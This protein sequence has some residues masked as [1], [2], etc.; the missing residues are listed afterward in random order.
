VF[1]RIVTRTTGPNAPVVEQSYTT[2]GQLDRI[3]IINRVT[4]TATTDVEGIYFAFPFGLSPGSCRLD[5]PFTH[6]RPGIDQLRYSAADFY[7]ICHWVEF[8]DHRGGVLWAS[9][10]APVVV[11]GDLW[12]ECWHDEMQIDS[13]LLLSYVMNNYWFTN[14]RR[15]QGG[16]LTFRYRVQAYGGEPDEIRSARF[17]LEAGAPLEAHVVRGGNRLP[18]TRSWFAVAPD[19]VALLGV[20]QA[21]DGRGWIVRLLELGVDDCAAELTVPPGSWSAAL[22]DSAERGERPLRVLNTGERPTVNVAMRRG[23]LATL[24]LQSKSDN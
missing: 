5:I 23:R 21:D 11:F 12:P 13:G 8:W 15:R 17:G 22:T 16:E 3:D 2:Y 9:I 10:E 7:S 6:M 24:R 1:D 14:Y 20:K 4:K 19:H 18:G